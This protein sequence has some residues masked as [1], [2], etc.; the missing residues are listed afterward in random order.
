MCGFGWRIFLLL[1]C[2]SIFACS[3]VFGFWFTW[4]R[5][6][7]RR[8]AGKGTG[9]AYRGCCFLIWR[10]PRFGAG[11]LLTAVCTYHI[12]NCAKMH[13]LDSVRHAHCATSHPT[14]ETRIEKINSKIAFICTSTRTF[15]AVENANVHVSLASQ[16]CRV[17]QG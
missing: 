4:H 15:D 5:A 16:C 11:T 1:H 14:F 9:S 7:H 12:K 8:D 17:G 10:R 13:T 6:A 3:S 2:R